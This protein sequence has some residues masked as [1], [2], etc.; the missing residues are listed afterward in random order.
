MKYIF[1]PVPSRRLGVSLGIDLVPFKTCPFDCI[2]CQLGPTTKRTLGRKE[3]VKAEEILKELRQFLRSPSSH[4]K[5]IDFITLSGS[6]EPTLNSQIR[7]IISGIKKMTSIPVA[8][9]TNSALL[10]RK[11]VRDSLKKAEV[12]IPSLDAASAKIFKEINRPAKGLE[13]KKIIR[14]L[15]DFK[16]EYRGQ[17]WLEVML[18]RKINTTKKE[19]ENLKEAIGRINP[20]R[21]QLNTVVRP[22]CQ[23]NVQALTREEMERIKTLLGSRTEIIVGFKSRNLPKK[24]KNLEQKITTMLKR[25]PATAKDLAD[26]LAIHRNEVL[27]Y[28]AV[29]VKREKIK[30]L[31]YKNKKYYQTK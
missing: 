22:P 24:M 8:V 18:I 25:R 16:E 6:G 14:G 13:I 7:Q 2:Y 9:L 1:G 28:L 12:V 21:I 20:D 3:Y 4:L 23:E 17:I 5:T 15:V 26:G 10:H 31:K 29:L 30:S 19:L 27:K 11:E